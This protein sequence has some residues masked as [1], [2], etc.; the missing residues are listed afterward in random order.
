MNDSVDF[1]ALWRTYKEQ[2][3][4]G[5][6]AAEVDLTFWEKAAPDYDRSHSTYPGVLAETM[7]KAIIRPNDTLLDVG[8]GTGRFALPLAQSVIKRASRSLSSHAKRS[9]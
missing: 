9:Q 7:I 8:A 1:A 4:N 3:D 6:V 5:R 2:D